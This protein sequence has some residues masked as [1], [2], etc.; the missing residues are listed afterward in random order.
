LA[1]CFEGINISLLDV[2]KKFL[3]K[4][5]QTLRDRDGGPAGPPPPGP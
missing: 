3:K 2:N 5:V 4:F 1:S